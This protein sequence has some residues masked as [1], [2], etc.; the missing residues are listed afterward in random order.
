MSSEVAAQVAH[1]RLDPAAGSFTVQAFAEGLFS[2]FGHDP[3]I[4]VKDFQGVVCAGH[5]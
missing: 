5:V 2:A 3:V 1:Y 4:G